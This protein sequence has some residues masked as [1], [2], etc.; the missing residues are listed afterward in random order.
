MTHTTNVNKLLK[1][2]QQSWFYGVI[3]EN[4]LAPPM[5]VIKHKDGNQSA[6]GYHFMSKK[7]Q[8][9]PSKGITLHFADNEGQETLQVEGRNLMPL[10]EALASHR[11]TFI[12]ELENSFEEPEEK[13]LCVM[14]I[15]MKT[16]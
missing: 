9:D 2:R 10:W 13:E 15:N 3:K 8:Y 16:L 7:I 5:L 4:H 6:Y 1:E 12:R 14:G 11:V